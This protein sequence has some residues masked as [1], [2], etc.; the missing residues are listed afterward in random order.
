[1]E[2]YFDI[3]DEN[4]KIIGRATR[5]E[6]HS[7]SSLVHRGVDVLIFDSKGR[8]LLQKRSMKKD[9]YPGLWT[10]SATG[11]NG[12][13]EGYREAAE[14]E[15]EE[16][17]GIRTNLRF[18]CSYRLCTKVESENLQIFTGVHDGPFHP[19]REE[20]DEVKFFD[21]PDAKKMAEDGSNVTPGFVI[22]FREYLKYSGR[23]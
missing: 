3:V 21:M 12:I 17:L 15:L 18:L 22:S 4:D 1:M 6:C 2:E 10:C 11:H 13:G 14:R 19:N 8:L 16:E 20:V 5:K 7:N 9:L 23:K